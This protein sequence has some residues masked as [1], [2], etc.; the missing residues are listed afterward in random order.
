MYDRSHEG[1]IE[2]NRLIIFP[3]AEEV[4]LSP[5]L[6]LAL[7]LVSYNHALLEQRPL[8]VMGREQ[9]DEYTIPG[10]PEQAEM[11]G[12]AVFCDLTAARSTT[13]SCV[14]SI[15]RALLAPYG[16]SV[17]KLEND[18]K[19]FVL[20]Q[21]RESRG[22]INLPPPPVEPEREIAAKQGP[23]PAHFEEAWR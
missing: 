2:N 23:K 9:M 4:A 20:L 15:S 14:V 8:R 3:K 13:V 12:N 7:G 1:E 5:Q 6:W 18:R 19:R 22:E 11:Q 17:R 16:I 21:V 10:R